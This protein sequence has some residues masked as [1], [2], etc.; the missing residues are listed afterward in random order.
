MINL[1]REN[2]LCTLGAVYRQASANIQSAI[3]QEL[4][5]NW[6]LIL[7]KRLYLLVECLFQAKWF[8][9]MAYD[10]YFKTRTVV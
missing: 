7:V 2:I 5:A 9:Q 1:N 10:H 3:R 8:I 6:I 4:T